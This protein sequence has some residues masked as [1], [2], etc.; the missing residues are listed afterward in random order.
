MLRLTDL[1]LPL[2]HADGDIEAAVLER[3]RIAPQELRGYSV[4][5]RA[6]DARKRSAIT[7]IYT[8]DMEVENEAAVLARLQGD[9]RAAAGARS[10]AIASSRRRRRRWAQ[11]PVVIGAG[12]CGL[13]AGLIL[14]QM[15]FRPIILERGK[16]VR[17]RTKDTWG[18]WRKSVLNPESNVQFGEGGAGTFSDGKL[19]S[20]IKDPRHL[21]RKVLTEFVKAGA[22]P[23]ILYVSQAAHRHLP[24]GDDGREHARDDRGAGRRISASS[25]GS[26]DIEIES[27]R[28]RA[29]R[30]RGVVLDERRAASRPI[31]SCWRS[32]HSARDT[33]E[34]LYERGVAIEAKPFSIGLRIE[35][36]QSLIDRAAAA[37]RRPSAARR[38]RLQAGASL[39]QRPLG[40]QLLHVSRRHGG[41]GDL[42]AGARRDQRHEPVFAQRAQRQRRHRG[43][44][45]AGR[46]S[47]TSA[48]RHR[49]PAPLGGARVR[50]GRRELLRAGAA[51]RRFSRG[52]AVDRAGRGGAVL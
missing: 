47:G 17:E 20:Q 51:G 29:R 1:K 10:R 4:F 21:G 25:S 18:L 35:H 41:G 45:H 40:L 9:R 6:V 50:G 2:D 48:R 5:R 16:V 13:F 46:L 28:R 7:L 19:Y 38:R 39:Q 23:E 52:R 32:G 33:F 44:H 31:T 8:L 15:G 26:T 30:M 34:M 43:R 36:P 27:G 37:Q 12:P 22:P 11:R 24:P 42:R 3:L 14:A 49:L